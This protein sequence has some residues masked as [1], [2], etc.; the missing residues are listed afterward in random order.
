MF[1]EGFS[2]TDEEMFV[3]TF[4]RL[5]RKASTIIISYLFITIYS[6]YCWSLLLLPSHCMTPWCLFSISG[7]RQSQKFIKL[8]KVTLD[9]SLCVVLNFFIRNHLSRYYSHYLRTPSFVSY[10]KFY[11]HRFTKSPLLET[12]YNVYLFGEIDSK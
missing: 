3:Q 4:Y 6:Y 1:V 10:A 12:I 7:S 5:F 11:D 2:F 8:S 9:S